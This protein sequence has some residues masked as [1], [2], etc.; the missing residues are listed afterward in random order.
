M[1]AFYRSANIA[2]GKMGEALAFAKE[3]AAYIKDQTGAEV[4][5]ALPIGGNPNRVGWSVQYD[6]LAALEEM[7]TKLMADPKYMEL[8]ASNSGNF[9]EGSVRDEIWSTF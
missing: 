2:G 3:I 1:I 5:V 9:V 8:V 4:S 6:D 7:N